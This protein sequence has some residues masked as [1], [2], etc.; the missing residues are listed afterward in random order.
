MNETVGRLTVLC[1]LHIASR[2]FSVQSSTDH[3]HVFHFPQSGTWRPDPQR[4]GDGDEKTLSAL[5]PHLCSKFSC[6]SRPMR[7]LRGEKQANTSTREGSASQFGDVSVAWG[8]QLREG[9]VKTDLPIFNNEAPRRASWHR[10]L[11]RAPPAR[12]VRPEVW[13]SDLHTAMQEHDMWIKMMQLSQRVDQRS[14][15]GASS[16]TTF[17]QPPRRP[18]TRRPFLG[19]TCAIPAQHLNAVSFR[20]RI[21]DLV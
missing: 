13:C 5:P 20:R 15:S 7:A 9:S 18:T 10:R 14:G 21:S 19:P 3:F 11:P 16:A 17:L 6:V 1:N 8:R 4:E 2:T 12:L